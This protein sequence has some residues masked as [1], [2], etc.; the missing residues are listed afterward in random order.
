MWGLSEYHPCLPKLVFHHVSQ[1]HVRGF[2][3]R[4]THVQNLRVG[5]SKGMLPVETT[6][7][8]KNL[9]MTARKHGH[10]PA[11]RLGWALLA[12]HKQKGAAPDPGLC[13]HCLQN[14]EWLGVRVGTW[15]IGSLSGRCKC[16]RI[17]NCCHYSHDYNCHCLSLVLV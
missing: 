15:N 16:Y 17:F 6:C 5:V 8:N 12:Y 2:S 9:M 3:L 11:Q 7:S 14:D 13:K 10:Q 1:N 4:T